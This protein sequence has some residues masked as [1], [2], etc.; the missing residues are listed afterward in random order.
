[1]ELKATRVRNTWRYTT[2]EFQFKFIDEKYHDHTSLIV[3]P[4]HI[5]I[6]KNTST[7]TPKELKDYIVGLYFSEENGET[8][9]HNNAVARRRRAKRKAT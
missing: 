3:K 7:R 6:L 8:R 5:Q 9:E 1:M 4:S 2:E